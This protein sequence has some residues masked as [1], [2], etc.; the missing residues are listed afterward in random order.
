MLSI[1]QWLRTMVPSFRVSVGKLLTYKRFSE[2]CIP[3][4]FL[5][6]DDSY[7]MMVMFPPHFSLSAMMSSPS[8]MR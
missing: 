8:Y 7:S 3:V 1:D 2:V 6:V 5:T 4:D